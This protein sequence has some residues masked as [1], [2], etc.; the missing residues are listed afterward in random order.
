MD[1]PPPPPPDDSE[2][3]HTLEHVCAVINV[4]ENVTDLET[5][6]TH[7]NNRMNVII[8]AP[9][10]CRRLNLHNKGLKAWLIENNVHVADDRDGWHIWN[11]KWGVHADRRGVCESWDGCD[12]VRWFGAPD[13][14]DRDSVWVHKPVAEKDWHPGWTDRQ[15][16]T[17]LGLRMFTH[18]TEKVYN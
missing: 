16:E 1:I 11:D 9:D 15:T 12:A 14:Q 3:N 5:I 17:L 18:H 10:I 6:W 7:V 4:M 2:T 8:S 13:L